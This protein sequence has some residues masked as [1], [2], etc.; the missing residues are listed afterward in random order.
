MRHK[1]LKAL[2]W[3]LV[4]SRPPT[5]ASPF[6]FA[7]FIITHIFNLYS[8]GEA[9]GL[10]RTMAI[11]KNGWGYHH[12]QQTKPETIAYAFADSPIGLLAWIYE[13]LHDWTDEYPWTEEEVCSWVSMY[14][15]SRSGPGASTRIYYETSKGDYPVEVPAYLPDVKLVGQDSM[16]FFCTRV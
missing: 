6:A 11:Q 16:I 4:P 3:N 15:F 9:K 12:I 10:E 2:H 7:S 1:N 14:W 13:K 8:H 5:L